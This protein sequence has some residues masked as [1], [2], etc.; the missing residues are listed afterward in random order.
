MAKDPPVSVVTDAHDPARE[1]AERAARR[2][3]AATSTPISAD[4]VQDVPLT[5]TGVLNMPQLVATLTMRHRDRM[6]SRP[7]SAYKK[8]IA[9]PPPSPLSLATSPVCPE[10]SSMPLSG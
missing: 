10:S 9:V 2:T 8:R 4:R 3:T 6:S 5:F 7:R 1:A